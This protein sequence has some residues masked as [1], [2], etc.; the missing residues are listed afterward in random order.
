MPRGAEKVHCWI[1]TLIFR[2]LAAT[3]KR[4]ANKKAKGNPLA[5]LFPSGR[6]GSGFA[7]PPASPP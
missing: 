6:R 2:A 7:G 3:R 5:F 4:A 1:E